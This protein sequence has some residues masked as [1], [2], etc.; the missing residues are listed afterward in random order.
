V[1]AF[2]LIGGSVDD[3]AV[4]AIVVEAAKMAAKL[5]NASR[6]RSSMESSGVV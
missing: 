3:L 2:P 6:R 1:T 4:S 5:P